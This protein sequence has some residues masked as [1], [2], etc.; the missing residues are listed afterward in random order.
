MSGKL[1]WGLRRQFYE[2]TAE[3]LRN[4][5]NLTD[6]LDGFRNRLARRGRKKKAEVVRQITRRIKNG[7]TLVD[8]MRG[9]LSPLERDLLSTGVHIGSQLP[10]AMDLI[11]EVR[12]RSSDMMRKIGASFLAPLVYLVSLYIT[13]FVVGDSVIPAFSAIVPTERWTGWAFVLYLLGSVATGWAVPLVVTSFVACLAGSFLALPRW[14]GNGAI[15][16]RA[17]FDK[18]VPLFAEYRELQGF[19]WLMA[20]AALYSSGVPDEAALASQ[21]RSATPWLAS[22]LQPLRLALKNGS[23]IDDA[24]RLTGFGFPSEDLID[25]IGSYVGSPSFGERITG[26]ARHYAKRLERRMLM[27]IALTSAF[28]TGVM[29]FAVFVVQMGSNALMTLISTAAH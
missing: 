17:F 2:Q 6:I 26:V 24:M 20:Y 9:N 25:E 14:T 22:R 4:E 13:L 21:I 15:K 29:F 1:S 28:F 23:R 10:E 3:Q 12:D 18:Y 27:K 19:T 7:E 16:G 8:A 5:N 11:V